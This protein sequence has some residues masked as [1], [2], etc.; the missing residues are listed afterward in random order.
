MSRYTITVPYNLRA[1]I[2][3]TIFTSTAADTTTFSSTN[4]GENYA[5]AIQATSGEIMYKIGTG[6]SATVGNLVME[7][8]THTISVRKTAANPSSIISLF[9]LTTTMKYQAWVFE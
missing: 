2:P 5:V 9:G 8:D 7:R 1:Q 3:P 6:A 4:Y